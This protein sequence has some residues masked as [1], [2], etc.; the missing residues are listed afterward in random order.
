MKIAIL[1]T[2]AYG[3]A[4]SSILIDNNHSVT[5]WTKFDTE[6]DNLL[7]NRKNEKLLP[8]FI[9]DK[10]IK[11]TN[12]LEEAIKDKDLI[13]I[14]I[15]TAY[16]DDLAKDME[17]YINNNHILIATKGIEQNTGLFVHEILAKHLKT[18][19]YAV[20]SGPSFAKD[21][22]KK[23]PVGLSL[24]GT[25]RQTTSLAHEALSN[26][27]I[28]LRETN[29]LIGIEA[30]GAIKNV[31]ALSAGMLEGL[32]ATDSTTAMFLTEATHDMMEILS[33][34]SSSRSTVTSFAGLGDLLLTCTSIQS[35][36]Y[37]YGLL[38]GSNKPKDEIDTYLKNTTVEG[39]YTLKSIH[40]LLHDLNVEVPII[41]LIYDII[42]KN[43]EPKELLTFLVE[44]A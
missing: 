13:I 39:Y 23:K 14:A 43:K 38:I 22:I 18:G 28:K 4:I 40:K 17:P 37:R 12:N 1:G 6:K 25:S 21:I 15:P 42:F 20:I 32:D 33:A 31:I 3:M 9:L 35:R 29:D 11:I 44:K 27:Y 5:M 10:D 24:A 30:C 7:K 19:N 34:L 36:N 26:S 2:G 16:I 41:D 8:G